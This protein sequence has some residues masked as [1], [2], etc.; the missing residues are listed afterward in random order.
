M[1][2]SRVPS[3]RTIR[4]GLRWLDKEGDPDVLA[5]QIRK[6]LRACVTDPVNQ[7]TG[8]GCR[9]DPA[10]DAL[11]KISK[12]TRCF[13]VEALARAPGERPRA[14]YVNTGDTYTATIAFYVPTRTFRVTSRGDIV[15]ADERRGIKYQ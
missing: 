11:D 2:T 1:A 7:W 6:I 8:G 4:E 10:H 3:V 15:E 5:R 9:A 14:Y 12:L 13:G